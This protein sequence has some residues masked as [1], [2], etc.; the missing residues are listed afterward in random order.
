MTKL[1]SHFPNLWILTLFLGHREIQFS[2]VFFFSE[3]KN[4][5]IDDFPGR[6]VRDEKQKKPFKQKGNKTNIL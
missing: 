4:L 2:R 3:A 6:M 5:K 1:N